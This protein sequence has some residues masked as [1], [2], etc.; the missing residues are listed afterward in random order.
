MKIFVILHLNMKSICISIIL[1]GLT[2]TSLCASGQGLYL[3]DDI[4]SG[5]IEIGKNYKQLY[6]FDSI[7]F[8][9]GTYD[10]DN[11]IIYGVYLN[12][13]EKF[14]FNSLETRNYKLNIIKDIFISKLG[15]PGINRGI[16]YI[17][18]MGPNQT[19][20]I[21]GWNINNRK[22][23]LISIYGRYDTTNIIKIEFYDLKILNENI[24]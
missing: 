4:V 19:Y 16:G 21:Y 22:I 17:P 11:N 12:S 14:K 1:I 3:Y 10:K 20:S 24:R 6:S 23:T 7:F 2:L 15:E 9:S 18:F 5:P 8:I 13:V